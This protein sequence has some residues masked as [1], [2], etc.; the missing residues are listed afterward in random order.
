VKVT[1]ARSALSDLQEIQAYYREQGV[2]DV[3]RKFVQAI[4]SKVQNLGDYP[5]SGRKVPEFDQDHIRELIHAPFRVAYL[6]DPAAVQL[7]R[8]WRSARLLLL[9]DKS[10]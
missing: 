7:I 10:G 2:P 3:G 4:F 9:P 5:D 1:I 8:V 6:R